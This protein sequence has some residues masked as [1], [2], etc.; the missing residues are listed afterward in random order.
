[1][2]RL[3]DGWARPRGRKALDGLALPQP[4]ADHCGDAVAAHADPV[5]GVRYF[6]APL[7]VRH[8]DELRNVSEFG[9]DFQEPLQVGTLR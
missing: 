7:L 1:M 2:G 3:T 6:H 8:D 9:Q 5:Q 4:L